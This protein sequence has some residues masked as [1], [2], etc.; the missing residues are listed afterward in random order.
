MALNNTSAIQ[1]GANWC[2]S[3]IMGMGRGAGNVNTEALMLECVN[4][5][6][7]AGNPSLLNACREYFEPLMRKYDWG[8]NPYYHF[9]LITKYTQ[10]MCNSF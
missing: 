10:L 3:T 4:H 7:H 1:S 2:D 8:A 9:A 5:G 6:L